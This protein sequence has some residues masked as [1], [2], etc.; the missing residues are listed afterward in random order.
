[1]KSI[2]RL[3]TQYLLV[4]CNG[5]AFASVISF[6][7]VS[8]SSPKR[9]KSWFSDG[10]RCDRYNRL[11]YLVFSLRSGNRRCGRR[12]SVPTI[13]WK[14][15][16]DGL[17]CIFVYSN[18]LVCIFLPSA[19]MFISRRRKQPAEEW[20]RNAKRQTWNTQI[21]DQVIF[22]HIQIPN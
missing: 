7:D 12:I 19:S 2:Q 14:K 8:L 1:M 4:N 21:L 10:T 9:I 15:N 5:D 17:R 18:L 20:T 6:I 11:T 22:D 3:Q 13:R 16:L